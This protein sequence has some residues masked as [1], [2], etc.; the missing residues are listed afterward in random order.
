MKP[1]S[2][3]PPKAPAPRT[4]QRRAEY[5]LYKVAFAYVWAALN[6]FDVPERDREEL[7]QEILF[8]AYAKRRVY[9]PERGSLARWLHGFV[10]NFAHKY[11]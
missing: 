6:H 4:Y 2:K 9:E 1:R 11:W 5:E 8:A 7:V 3:D 10:V